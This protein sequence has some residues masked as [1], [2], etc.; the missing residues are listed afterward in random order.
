MKMPIAASLLILPL[1]VRYP[2]ANAVA[3]LATTTPTYVGHVECSIEGMR[4]IKSQTVP[5]PPNPLW[6]IPSPSSAQRR[7]MT[8]ML[9]VAQATAK[10]QSARKGGIIEDTVNREEI[11]TR[12][13]A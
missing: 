8:K 6:L 12:R 5:A 10:E 11:G 1:R 3:R 7:E 2:I 9:S 4:S 13:P